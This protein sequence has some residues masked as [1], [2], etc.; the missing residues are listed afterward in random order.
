MIISD[1][2]D[3]VHLVI[4]SDSCVDFGR[5]ILINQ[6]KTG[7]ILV[8]MGFCARFRDL[9]LSSQLSPSNY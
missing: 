1:S 5:P 2:M 9:P 3:V 6:L 4:D 8:E 7:D